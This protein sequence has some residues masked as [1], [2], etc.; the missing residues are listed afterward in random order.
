MKS[1]FLLVLSTVPNAKAG[2]KIAKSLVGEKLAACVNISAPLHSIYSWKGKLCSEKE[3]LL[4]IKTRAALY[5]KLEKRLRELHPYE[6]P[7]IIALPIA[8]G[9]GD[10]LAWLH[11]QTL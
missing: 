2:Q 7:E 9:S 10:Y 11:T 4:L 6:V 3:Q 5:K 8:R 1:S